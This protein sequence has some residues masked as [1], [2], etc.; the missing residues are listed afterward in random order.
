MRFGKARYLA[1]VMALAL[2][3]TAC[4]GDDDQSA[5]DAQQEAASLPGE[6][7]NPADRDDLQDGGD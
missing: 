6:D 5:E 4:G 2:M 1:P 3:A 7:L